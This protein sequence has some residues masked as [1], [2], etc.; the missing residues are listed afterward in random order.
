MIVFQYWTR[1]L[2]IDNVTGK[3]I[4]HGKYDKDWTPDH[5]SYDSVITP[6]VSGYTPDRT[7]VSAGLVTMENQYTVVTYKKTHHADEKPT[8]K[9]YKWIIRYIDEN[10][11][12]LRSAIDGGDHYQTGA[13]FDGNQYRKNSITVDGKIYKLVLNKSTNI[14]GKFSDHNEVTTFV[15]QAMAVPTQPKNPGLKTPEKTV[16]PKTPVRSERPEKPAIPAMKITTPVTNSKSKGNVMATSQASS[17]QTTKQAQLPQTGN[18]SNQAVAL[19]ILGLM[20][21][22]LAGFGSD[23]NDKKQR[24]N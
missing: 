5:S 17:E 2:T 6:T 1:T 24:R 18:A 8:T 22:F 4:A 23:K 12:Q 14:S 7:V 20:G 16:E 3:I 9:T 10:G 15:Y 19:G 13:Y 11:H 21:S